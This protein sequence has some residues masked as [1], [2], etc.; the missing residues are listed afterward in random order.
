MKNLFGAESV[1][2]VHPLGDILHKIES[3]LQER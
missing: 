3:L 2:Q 1:E